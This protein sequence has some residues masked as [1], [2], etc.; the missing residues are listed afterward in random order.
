MYSFAVA[1]VYI[2]H[3]QEIINWRIEFCFC[4]LVKKTCAHYWHF[5]SFFFLINF[6]LHYISRA[7]FARTLNTRIFANR[8]FWIL[9]IYLFKK[10]LDN[11]FYR[12]PPC[13]L[14]QWLLISFDSTLGW[15]FLFYLSSI[16]GEGRK[17]GRQRNVTTLIWF[18]STNYK[19][20]QQIC[21]KVV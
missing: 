3:T 5:L 4:F 10:K 12:S 20:Q 9:F 18:Y 6:V 13:F 21:V 15:T 1:F 7:P 11:I 2:Y 19:I 14:R 17:S 8:F 16:K